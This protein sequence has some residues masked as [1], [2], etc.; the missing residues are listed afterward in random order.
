MRE[1]VELYKMGGGKEGVFD[2]MKNGFG[3]E[4]VGKWLMGE[5]RV[6]VVVRGVI[7]N[8]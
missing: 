8:L 4:R 1:M 3:W 6:L 5:N 2:E 7:G